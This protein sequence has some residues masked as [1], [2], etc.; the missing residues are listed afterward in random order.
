MRE[1]IKAALGIGSGAQLSQHVVDVTT[2]G[3]RSGQPRR[4]E[5]AI[6]TLDDTVYLSGIPVEHPRAWLLNLQAHPD[7]TLHVK[8]GI[9]ADLPAHAEVITDPDERE[10]ILPLFGD[11]FMANRDPDGP[12]PATTAE[13]WVQYSPLARVSFV[14]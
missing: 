1:E 4:I 11:A 14:D 5:I 13:Q 6:R 10:R 2:V 7:F 9:E 3:R 8:H 12:Y